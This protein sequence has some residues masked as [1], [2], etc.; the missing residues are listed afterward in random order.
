M[1]FMIY[2]LIYMLVNAPPSAGAAG[3]L[4]LNVK[5]QNHVVPTVSPEEILQ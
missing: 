5:P 3:S 4:A 1:L 2:D